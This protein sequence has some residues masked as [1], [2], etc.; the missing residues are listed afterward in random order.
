[1]GDGPE[2]SRDVGVNEAI[3]LGLTLLCTYSL[4]SPS[5]NVLA[6]I[7]HK[8]ARLLP[9]SSFL[10]LTMGLHCLA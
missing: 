2:D 3:R 5:E 1:M 4:F 7:L 6:F 10:S 8:L 9:L